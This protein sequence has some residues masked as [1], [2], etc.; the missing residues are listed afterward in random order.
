MNAVAN[1]LGMPYIRVYEVAT[2]YTMFNR[3]FGRCFWSF[4][5]SVTLLERTTSKSAP[6][7]LAWSV[8]HTTSSRLSKKTLVRVFPLYVLIFDAGISAGETTS[9]GK[10]TVTEVECLGA[11]VNAPMIQVNDEFY[12]RIVCFFCVF[13]CA[14]EDLKPADVHVILN[15]LKKGETPNPGPRFVCSV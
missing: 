1:I 5:T 3:Y 4:H 13:M 14:Q 8:G 7:P 9:D 12:V 10:F 6:Q 2:F 15:Q 11:C